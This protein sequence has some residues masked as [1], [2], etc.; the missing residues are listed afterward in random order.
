MIGRCCRALIR[1]TLLLGAF[2]V[3]Y[4]PMTV[5]A[6]PSGP[7]V[8]LYRG[9]VVRSV[10]NESHG[11]TDV[12]SAGEALFRDADSSYRLVMSET[13]IEEMKRKGALLEIVYPAI[14]TTNLLNRHTAHFLKLLIPLSGQF[15]DGTVFFAGYWAQQSAGPQVTDLRAYRYGATTFVLNSKGV[16][17]LK[18]ALVQAGFPAD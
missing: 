17:S 11:F 7:Q 1:S 8:L 5:I 9:G 16:H 6:N 4:K 12:L 10:P 2:A 15:T 13:R 18:A 3:L 14:Q